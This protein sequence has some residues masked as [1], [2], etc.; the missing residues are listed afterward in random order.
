MVIDIDFFTAL[1]GH[2]RMAHDDGRGS[3]DTIPH[4]VGRQWALIDDLPPVEVIGDACGI[5][6]PFLAGGGQGGQ[7]SEPLGAGQLVPVIN[8]TK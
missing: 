4:L 5:C 7:Q 8:E 3:R 1:G 6:S 2:S